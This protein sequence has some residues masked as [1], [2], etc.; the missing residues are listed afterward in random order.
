MKKD[1]RIIYRD[2]LNLWMKPFQIFMRITKY[3]ILLTK[4]AD[5]DLRAIYEYIVFT[6]EIVRL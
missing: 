1:I 4:Q 2:M 3:K 6:F 5:A